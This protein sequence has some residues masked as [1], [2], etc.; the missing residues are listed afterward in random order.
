MEPS[1]GVTLE[2]TDRYELVVVTRCGWEL[3]RMHASPL[4]DTI[5]YTDAP[6][7]IAAVIVAHEAPEPAR[8]A[9]LIL[10]IAAIRWH[11]PLPHGL[12]ITIPDD[13]TEDSIVTDMIDALARLPDRP[14]NLRL[15]QERDEFQAAV[16]RVK[17]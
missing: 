15:Q 8:T 11:L 5:P 9:L 4:L 10:G 14:G 17:P 16:Q 12:V 7:D 1:G 3:F 2:P 13:S 6:S